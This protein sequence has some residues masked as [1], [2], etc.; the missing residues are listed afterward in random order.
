MIGREVVGTQRRA[1]RR[2][3]MPGTCASPADAEDATMRR[4]AL[5]SG[6]FLALLALVQLTRLLLAWPVQ[7]A[8]VRVPLWPS[9]AAVVI[10]GSLALWAFRAARQRAV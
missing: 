10:A 8:G 5:V 9:A 1:R 6:S 3:G 4:Y 2:F 7:V